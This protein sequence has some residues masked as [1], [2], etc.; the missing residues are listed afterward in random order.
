M[1]KKTKILI[2]VDVQNDFID[3]SLFN[4]EAI[5]RV[6]NI[7]KKING[8]NGDYIIATQDT[9]DD[10]YMSTKEG[11]ALPVVHCIKGTDGWK[12]NDSVEKALTEAEA[13]KMVKRICK[14]TFGSFDLVDAV[15]SIWEAEKEQGSKILEIEICGFC[16]DI[17]IISNALMLKAAFYEDATISVIE[18]C[19]AGVTEESHKAALTTMKMCQINIH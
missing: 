7:V 17:C 8:F 5:V 12:I 6:P 10:N 19:C 15:K 14:P 16:S 9:H 13:K 4:P 1:L 11:K 18:N 2:V 3:G